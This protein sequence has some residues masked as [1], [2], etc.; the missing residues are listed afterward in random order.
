[1][2]KGAIAIVTLLILIVA[3]VVFM[4]LKKKE[5]PDE[6]YSDG[7]SD[8][9]VTM[10]SNTVDNLN[11][12]RMNVNPETNQLLPL[13]NTS[14][15][16][17]NSY[18]SDQEDLEIVKSPCFLAAR[19]LE[20]SELNKNKE[21]TLM[22]NDWMDVGYASPVN[23]AYSGGPMIGSDRIYRVSAMK[24]HTPPYIIKVDAKE[25]GNFQL[26]SNIFRDKMLVNIPIS[27]NEMETS[28]I[29]NLDDSYSW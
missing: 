12:Y 10:D 3:F 16:F 4:R 21:Q 29:I 17:L 6:G 7:Y 15:D 25:F 5:N 14:S 27:D 13:S 22:R 18:I 23:M 1:M 20:E 9:L 28:F 2:K 19:E 26:E 8:G 24:G 11:Y